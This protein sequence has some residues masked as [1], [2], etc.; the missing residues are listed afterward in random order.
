MLVLGGNKTKEAED[1]ESAEQTAK[2]A[3]IESSTTDA[4]SH[5]AP[6]DEGAHCVE[7]V[8]TKGEVIRNVASQACL[9]KEVRGIIGEGVACK[10]LGDEQ[11]ADN[12]G[13]PEVDSLETIEVGCPRRH[14]LLELVGVPHHVDGFLSVEG[15]VSLWGC[16]SKKRLLGVF[17][18]T[19]P[20]EPPG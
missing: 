20:Y 15:G 12:F 9:L 3:K 17:V 10:V 1:K 16:E 6:R 19:F 11:H 13:T 18:S 7:T 5:E 14:V 8:L 4:P 2:A